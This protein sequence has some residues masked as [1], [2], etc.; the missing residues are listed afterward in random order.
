[1]WLSIFLLL[2]FQGL[3][4]CGKSRR[5]RWLNYLRPNLKRGNYTKEEEETI[6]KLHRHLGNRYIPFYVSSLPC[7]IL[8]VLLLQHRYD[9]FVKNRITQGQNKVLIT[10][11]MWA[12]LLS[13]TN[14]PSF[15][16]A[17]TVS[18][19]K[20]EEEANGHVPE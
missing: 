3:A 2:C 11:R 5:L 14:L 7:L 4:R 18:K 10:D 13:S 9:L 16:I 12:R 1:M 8:L 15:I 20:R 17:K 19:E 6:I